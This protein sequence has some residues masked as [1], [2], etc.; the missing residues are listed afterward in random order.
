[1]KKSATL[2]IVGVFAIVVAAGVAHVWL[3]YRVIR[4]GYAMGDRLQAVREL[5]EEER[6]LRLELAALR[7]PARIEKLAREKLN[8]VRPSPERIRVVRT[9][10]ELARVP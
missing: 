3:R 1:M 9:A 4:T 5:E 2:F 6:K 7:N 8:M 10:T